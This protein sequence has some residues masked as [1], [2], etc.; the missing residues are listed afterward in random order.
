MSYV[1]KQL[2]KNKLALFGLVMIVLFSGAALF[3]PFI[4]PHPPDKQF[5]EGNC[6]RTG[7]LDRR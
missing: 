5:F 7:P 4:T 3:A 1:L 6:M 2:L